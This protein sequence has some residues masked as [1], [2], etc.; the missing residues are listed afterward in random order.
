MFLSQIRR[1]KRNLK[2]GNTLSEM[3]IAIT[4]IGIVFV[5]ATGTMVADYHKNQ[6]VVRLKKAYSVFEIKV[7]LLLDCFTFPSGIE[8]L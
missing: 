3:L 5:I 7:V 8:I 6:T 1:K 2:R 4:I